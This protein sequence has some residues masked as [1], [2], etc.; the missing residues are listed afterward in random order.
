VGH[1]GLFHHLGHLSHW[2][3]P[4]IFAVGST[5]VVIA[6][7]FSQKVKARVLP[8]PAALAIPVVPVKETLKSSPISKPPVAPKVTPMRVGEGVPQTF[9]NLSVV[10][11]QAKAGFVT[12]RVLE[13][14]GKEIAVLYNGELKPGAWAFQWDGKLADGS[15]APAGYYRIEIKTGSFIQHKIIQI[16]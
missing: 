5:S 11:G 13:P 4:A 3:W 1:V 9:S 14:G 8:P 2:I 7:H 6:W 15:A 10:V 12:V 16:Q